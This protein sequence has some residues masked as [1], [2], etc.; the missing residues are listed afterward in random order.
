MMYFG[1]K[2]RIASKL[3]DFINRNFLSGN[4]R[5]FV[6]L[7]CGSCNIMI[8]IDKGRV[9]IANDKHKYLI[10]MWNELQNGWIPP[11]N[12]TEEYYRYIKNNQQDNP[13]IS[14]FIGFGCSYSG[15]WWGGFARNSGN[16]NYCLNAHNST[17]K[18]MKHLMDV[19]F[20]NKDYFDV[21]I[22]IGAVVYCDIPYKN[23]T[24]YC[25]LEVGKFNHD[26]FYEWVRANKE[27]YTILISEYK[28]NI[29]DDFNILLE[30]ESKQDIRSKDGTKKNT[31]E[32]LIMIK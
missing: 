22:P 30:I 21:E 14:G 24:E 10:S 1:G 3:T 6:D 25:S 15:K 9:R 4:T 11:K 8:G 12:I 5:E 28:Q 19:R 16:R 13:Y 31:N 27:K 17:M 32:V 29:P 23:T 26:K 20:L 2:Q 7:F 18:K